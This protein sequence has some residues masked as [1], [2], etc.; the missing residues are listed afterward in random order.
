MVFGLLFNLLLCFFIYFFFVSFC[1]YYVLTALCFVAV[2]LS[3]AAILKGVGS[4]HSR[5]VL[6]LPRRA[7]RMLF[8]G[9][10]L[11]LVLR[12]LEMLFQL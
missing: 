11:P 3:V 7:S 4:L 12:S 9:L 5:L 1:K 10:S 2:D 6:R 8:R